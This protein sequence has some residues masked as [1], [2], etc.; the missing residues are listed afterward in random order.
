MLKNNK[1]VSWDSIPVDYNLGRCSDFYGGNL[2]GIS[3]KITYLRNLG[4]NNICL[5]PIFSSSSTHKYNVDDFFNVDYYLGGKL[6]LKHLSE[7]IHNNNMKLI[8]DI[9]ISYTSCKNHWFKN[10]LAV[11]MMGFICIMVKCTKA[12]WEIENF[13]F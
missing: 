2:K 3:E 11:S 13:L 5:S 10:I 6:A 4:V 12:L 8:L 7:I 1:I 9:P